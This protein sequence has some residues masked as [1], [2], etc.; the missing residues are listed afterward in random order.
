MNYWFAAGAF[1][2]T[3]LCFVVLSPLAIKAGLL[4]KPGGRKLHDDAT[5]LIGGIGIYLGVLVICL[6][7][8]T[9]L[10]SVSVLLGISAVVLLI[11]VIDDRKEMSVGL[12]MAIHSTAAFLM[13]I[14]ADNQLLSLGDLVFTGSITLDFFSIPLTVFAVL[15]VINA[16][17][18]SDGIDGLSGGLV[19]ISLG[20]L[21]VVAYAAGSTALLAFITILASSLF[22][23]LMF[24]YRLP[25][26]SRARIYLGDAGSTVL[27]FILAWLLIDS[28]QGPNQIMPPVLALWFIA[29]PLID[30]VTLLIKRPIKGES[31]FKSGRDHLHHL[32]LDAG[33][34]VE[35]VVLLLYGAAML[36]G[37]VGLL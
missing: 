19:L 36:I 1:A 35:Y 6:L 37:L 14:A 12:R 29:L 7:M 25:W 27:G 4:D 11:G 33:Y 15:G 23:F 32:L 3:C 8:P 30:T 13:V 16:V 21:G 22:A 10:V 31:S 2:I 18:M 34:K 20:F 5:P 24:N 28:T 26:N 9:V 17:N